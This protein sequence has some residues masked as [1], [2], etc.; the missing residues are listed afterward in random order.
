MYAPFILSA[1]NEINSQCFQ[2]INKTVPCF[3]F[4]SSCL[5]DSLTYLSHFSILSVTRRECLHAVP[6]CPFSRS[7]QSLCHLSSQ[8]RSF[9]QWWASWGHSLSAW[10]LVVVLYPLPASLPPDLHTYIIPNCTSRMQLANAEKNNNSCHLATHANMFTPE[11][12]LSKEICLIQ[13]LYMS[14][15]W[16]CC[17]IAFSTRLWVIFLIPLSGLFL[18]YGKK[19]INVVCGVVTYYNTLSQSTLA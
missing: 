13:I 11:G 4:Y 9:W 15:M 12:I 3:F 10:E 1:D 18:C 16:P 19:K 7:S 8:L 5:I 14:V 17:L 6:F 2:Y